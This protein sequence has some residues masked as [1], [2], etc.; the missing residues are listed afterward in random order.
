MKS[1]CT[2]KIRPYLRSRA[3][4]SFWIVAGRRDYHDTWVG[5]ELDGEYYDLHSYQEIEGDPIE[6]Y[7]YA[8]RVVDGFV[9]TDTSTL[10]DKFLI[11]EDHVKAYLR[12]KIVF[13][14]LLFIAIVVSIV[15]VLT[16]IF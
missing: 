5:F 4:E 10:I 7:I 6:V 13:Q 11:P 9:E 16:L 12:D 15:Y 8:C 14:V 3:E 2:V 1:K